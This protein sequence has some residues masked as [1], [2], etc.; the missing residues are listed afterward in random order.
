MRRFITI[1]SSTFIILALTMCGQAQKE[2]TITK[3]VDVHS[4]HAMIDSL[5]DEQIL[6]VR[7]PQEWKSGTIAGSKKVDW[8][9][10]DFERAVAGMDKD[11][12]VLVYCAVGGRSS[13][14]MDKLK[15]LGFSEIYNLKGGIRAWEKSSYEVV[16]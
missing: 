8:Y 13:Q 10:P 4:F 16:R 14:A 7:T 11:K 12:P 6:D 5:D 3:D 15:E 9:D 1:A 2:T